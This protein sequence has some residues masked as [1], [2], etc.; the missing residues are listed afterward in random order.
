[1]ESSSSERVETCS[2][3]CELDSWVDKISCIG[4]NPFNYAGFLFRYN[5]YLT[6]IFLLEREHVG[7]TTPDETCSYS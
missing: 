4:T 3:I 6:I 1:M 7:P 2:N 5:I